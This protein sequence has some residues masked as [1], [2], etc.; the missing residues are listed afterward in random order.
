MSIIQSVLDADSQAILVIDNRGIVKHINAKAK[1]R[2]GLT[3]KT[4]HKHPA[5]RLKKGDLVIISDNSIGSD[6]GGLSPEDF[7]RIGISDRHIHTGN[8]IVAAG[9]Y[10]DA[11]PKSVYK[12]I[13]PDEA[14]GLQLDTAFWNIPIH[15][16]VGNHNA[17]I[18]VQNITYPLPYFLCIGQM[19]VIDQDS[20]AVKFFQTQGYSLRNEGIGTLLRGG[21]YQAKSPGCEVNVVGH[22]FTEYFHGARF[23]RDIADILNGKVGKFP[24]QEYDLNG[25][26]IVA[27]LTPLLENNDIVGVIV[28]FRNMQEMKDVI[29][30]RNAAIR[31]VERRFREID[32]V[33][34]FEDSNAF[35]SLFGNSTARSSTKRYAYKLARLNCDIL[36]CGENG[37]GKSYLAR[38]I[39]S[40]QPRKGPLFTV[41]C[42]ATD[43]VSLESVLFGYGNTPGL[44]EKANGGTLILD[45]ISE[46]PLHT[47]MQLMETLQTRTV[48][49]RGTYESCPIDVRLIASSRKNLQKMVQDAQFRTDLYYYLSTF[50]LELPPLRNC[51]EELPLI[52]NNL[53]GEIREKYNMPEKYLSGEVFSDLVAYDWPGNIR[54][55][56]NVLERAVI[57]SEKEII[58]PEHIQLASTPGELTLKEQLKA[59]ERRIL[60]KAVAMYGSDRRKAMESLGL[61]RSVF[62]AKMKEHGLT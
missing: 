38:T 19:V 60:Q 52:I 40:Y 31:S 36:I 27:T 2:F 22:K 54:E 12:S 11:G 47:Q 53:L 21:E 13:H 37:T 14:K 59:E 58:Y 51:R 4:E 18:T 33:S 29:M 56:E 26:A 32:N 43:A 35:S 45:E 25:F 6:D 49:R 30:E 16:Q 50:S 15:V 3:T 44:F 46:M 17:S 8:M 23:E 48:T 28:H 42:R 34:T 10:Q 7:E 9:I 61:S 20:K 1:D 55:L 57:I 24:D 62:Y 39:V 41:D 5:G